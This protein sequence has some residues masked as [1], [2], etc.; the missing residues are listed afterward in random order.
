[1]PQNAGLITSNTYGV[2]AL[3]SDEA[4]HASRPMGYATESMIRRK[5]PAAVDLPL[6]GGLV[7]DL[8]HIS[9]HLAVFV[10]GY[11]LVG[12]QAGRRRTHINPR[13]KTKLTAFLDR[14]SIR[15][16]WT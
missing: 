6:L 14:E 15:I 3:G 12:G 16:R 9:C 11:R 4:V 5:M 13:R 2:S 1:M 8:A 7:V 10:L